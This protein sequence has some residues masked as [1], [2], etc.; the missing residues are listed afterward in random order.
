MALVSA[1]VLA[2][3]PQ[4][5]Q[6]QR[7]APRALS[8][9][10]G[11]GGSVPV[12]DFAK[13]VKTGW[14]GHAFLQYQPFEQGPWAVRAE[15][16]YTRSAY[17]DDLLTDVGAV[18]GDDLSNKVLYAGAAAAYHFGGSSGTV[19]PYVIGGLG[20]YEV[21]ASLKDEDGIT[22]SESESGFGFN[23]GAGLRFGGTIGF[24]VEARFHQFSITPRD[25]LKATS[26]FIP[27]SFGLVF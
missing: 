25:G 2:I 13:D 1:L 18:V 27:V 3:A 8:V 23:G 24:F 11:G 17:T 10:L 6:G 19:R 22:Y 14:N 26:Q 16:Q 5:A 12:G 21:T 20:L 15:A 4:T 9:G 7:A